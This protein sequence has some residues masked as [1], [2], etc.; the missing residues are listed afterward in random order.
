MAAICQVQEDFA[1]IVVITHI[2]ELR[3]QF[4]NRIE[5]EKGPSGSRVS[6]VRG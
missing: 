1:M 2:E 6:V 3:E 4:P 5:V